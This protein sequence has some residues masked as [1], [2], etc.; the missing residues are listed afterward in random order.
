M[1]S[2]GKPC[3]LTQWLYKSN[4]ALIFSRLRVA[5]TLNTTY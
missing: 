4:P 3:T 5:C 1:E 2:S